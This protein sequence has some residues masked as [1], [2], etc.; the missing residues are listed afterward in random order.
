MAV[1]VAM[2]VMVGTMA[3][4]GIMMAGVTEVGTE[5]GMAVGVEGII[6]IPILTTTITQ[7]TA[8]ITTTH[9]IMMMEE[10]DCIY[11]LDS[12]TRLG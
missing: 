1:M 7:E 9:L 10:A 3:A 6:T 11:S 2:G 12:K 4:G 8:I 5:V